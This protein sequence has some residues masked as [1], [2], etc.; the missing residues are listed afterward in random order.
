MGARRLRRVDRVPIWNPKFETMPR[1]H[2]GRLQAERLKKIVAYVS[3]RVPFY[4]AKLAQTL[5]VSVDVKLAGPKTLERSEGK[6]RRI[7]DKRQLQ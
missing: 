6:T 7:I 2:L 1:R 3:E 4:K 5:G